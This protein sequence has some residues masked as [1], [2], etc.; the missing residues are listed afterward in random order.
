[1][2]KIKRVQKR[3]NLIFSVMD[4]IMIVVFIVEI[5]DF[6]CPSLIGESLK[7]GNELYNDIIITILAGAYLLDKFLYEFGYYKYKFIRMTIMISYVVY[8]FIIR[9]LIF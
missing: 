3:S 1:M 9:K 2:I 7:V 4:I 6:T 5:I 8:Y